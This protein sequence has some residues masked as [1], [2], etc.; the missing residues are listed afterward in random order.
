MK[1]TGF[2]KAICKAVGADIEKALNS[3]AVKYG[4]NIKRGNGKFSGNTLDLKIHCACVKGG[5]VMSKEA[6]DFKTMASLYGLKPSDL[7]RSF[8]IGSGT[9]K[10]TGLNTKAHKYPIN[11]S[12]NGS[13]YKFPASSVKLLLD[14]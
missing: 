14:K 5:K 11:A 9:F 10:I 4:I 6:S 3:V 2:D 12:K 7:G 1:V 8:T 13:G